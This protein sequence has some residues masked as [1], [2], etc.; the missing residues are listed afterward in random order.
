MTDLHIDLAETTTG[1][2][3]PV[4]VMRAATEALHDAVE[5]ARPAFD[6]LADY[7]VATVGPEL[8]L[9]GLIPPQR[10]VRTTKAER[11]V[12][13]QYLACRRRAAPDVPAVG[14]AACARRQ[15]RLASGGIM[16]DLERALVQPL[17]PC[18]ESLVMR[19]ARRGALR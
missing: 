12:A 5:E 14:I 3:E 8:R 11:R 17:D 15:R 4:A 7:I 13:K 6:A 18:T 10:A 19:G 1:M 9:I 2:T 16:A